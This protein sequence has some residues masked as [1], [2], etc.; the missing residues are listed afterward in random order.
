MASSVITTQEKIQCAGFG[1]K[2]MANVFWDSGAI[3]S[4]E[5]LARGAKINSER[6]EVKTT[7]SKFS[8]K[9]GKRI[10]PSS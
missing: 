2:V 6:Y 4:V 10:K 8:A 5:F 1:C 3:L 9:T 7:N